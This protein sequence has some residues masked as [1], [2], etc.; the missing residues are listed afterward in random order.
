MGCKPSV[1]LYTACTAMAV[2][3]YAPAQVHCFVTPSTTPLTLASPPLQSLPKPLTMSALPLMDEVV[4]ATKRHK[5][6]RRRPDKTD[7][8]D[9]NNPILPSRLY[10]MLHHRHEHRVRVRE[11]RRR[12]T[13]LRNILR[14][15]A[16]DDD[17]LFADTLA[18]AFVSRKRRRRL[19]ENG[20]REHVPSSSSPPDRTTSTSTTF[21][22]G[23]WACATDVDTLR[24]MF[25]TNRN[26]LWGDLDNETARRLYH[27]LLPR[28]LLGLY[29]QGGLTPDELAPLAFEARRAAKQYARERSHVPGRVFATAYDG[30][31]HLKTYGN[32]SS[33]GLSWEELWSKYEEQVR[34]EM[35]LEFLDEHD[36]DDDDHEIVDLERKVCL[37]ILERSCITNAQIDK[38]VLKTERLEDDDVDASPDPGMELV[39]I[40]SRFEHD[41]NTLLE[42]SSKFQRNG[43]LTARDFFLLRLLVTTKKNLLMLQ[44][45]IVS[46]TNANHTSNRVAVPKGEMK[47]WN[48]PD[49]TAPAA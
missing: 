31:R 8:H 38:L 15:R 44:H 3:A 49:M 40:A 19:E 21:D 41:V 20:S 45:F 33:K 32:W 7:V 10:D 29:R 23:S 14:L 48:K 13:R 46:D 17:V 1:M 36:D 5:N 6:K 12:K 9:T 18:S 11:L 26:R 43:T 22:L 30:F 42:T 2:V 34:Q 47:A 37:K 35:V 25:G 24:S 28:T 4:T 27:T 16:D 39:A